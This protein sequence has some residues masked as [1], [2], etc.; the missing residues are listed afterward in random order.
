MLSEIITINHQQT[1]L[2]SLAIHKLTTFGDDQLYIL[3]IGANMGLPPMSASFYRP[4]SRSSHTLGSRWCKVHLPTTETAQ[5]W[6]T[7]MSLHHVYSNPQ[8][9]SKALDR[10][11]LYLTAWWASHLE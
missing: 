10:L 4:Q 11:E 2:G 6:M 9:L 8:N 5:I 3:Q 1:R 7:F